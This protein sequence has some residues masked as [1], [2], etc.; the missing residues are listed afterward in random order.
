MLISKST[1]AKVWRN[2]EEKDFR[3]KKMWYVRIIYVDKQKKNILKKLDI[4]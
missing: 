2:N 4:N 3:T 1:L